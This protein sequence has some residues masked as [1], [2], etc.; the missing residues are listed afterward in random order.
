MLEE[1]QKMFTEAESFY[2]SKELDI[3]SSLQRRHIS[4]EEGKKGLWW[5]GSDLRF[6]WNYY[7]LG[8]LI[9]AEVRKNEIKGVF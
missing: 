4:T 7:M 6:F 5:E 3:T 2:F 1:F 9:K 8:S